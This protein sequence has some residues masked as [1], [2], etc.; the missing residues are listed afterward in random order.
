MPDFIEALRRRLVELGCPLKQVRRLVREVTDHR[1]DL[2]QAAVAEGLSGAD[3]DARANASL[4][5]P[6]VLAEELMTALRRSSWWGRH[7]VVTFCLLPLLVYPILWAL[8]LLL[9]LALGFALGYGW[10]WEKLHV[11]VNNPATFHHLATVYQFMDYAA[12]ALVTL[13]FCWL[14]R[15]AVVKLKWMVV[16]C[17]ICSVCAMIWWGRI[18][19]NSFFLGFSLNSHLHMPWFRGVIPLLV[20]GAVYVCQRRSRQRFQEKIAV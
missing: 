4:G 20:V 7:F 6:L 2:K 11:V 9:Q 15:R 19:P 14:A 5:D 1:E 12:I 3:A 13:L 18:E 8:L 17:A 10:N 16:S